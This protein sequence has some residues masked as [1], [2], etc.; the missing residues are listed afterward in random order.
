MSILCTGS[1]MKVHCVRLVQGDD[2][3]LSLQA[4]VKD[5]Q[6]KAGFIISCVGSV[7]RVTLRFATQQNGD[8]EVN[9]LSS[10]Y[11]TSYLYLWRRLES[12]S[13]DPS[14]NIG[15]FYFYK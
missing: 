8:H 2:L 3:K 5:N 11:M 4:F 14:S 6:I 9:T 7:S 13:H 10:S 12:Q 15:F 1:N